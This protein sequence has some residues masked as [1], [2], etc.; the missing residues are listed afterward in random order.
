MVAPSQLV[1]DAQRYIDMNEP[2]HRHST[3][4]LRQVTD[5]LMTNPS[6]RPSQMSTE[7]QMAGAMGAYS[8]PGKMNP[9]VSPGDPGYV[10]PTASAAPVPVA[11][12]GAPGTVAP[13]P[14][15]TG[16]NPAMAGGPSV[17][18]PPSAMM[19]NRDLGGPANVGVHPETVRGSFMPTD[20]LYAPQPDGQT[21]TGGDGLPIP[22]PTY[23]NVQQSGP[24]V[25]MGTGDTN[26]TPPT[27]VPA[28][29]PPAMGDQAM[30]AGSGN[31]YTSGLADVIAAKSNGAPNGNNGGGVPPAVA[32]ESS[33]DPGPSSGGDSSSTN[34][35]KIL[36]G[37]VGG[38]GAMYG[39]ARLLR[40]TKS[41]GVAKG[42]VGKSTAVAPRGSSSTATGPALNGE[43]IPPN[44]A[45]GPKRLTAK[46]TVEQ[47]VPSTRKA[48]PSSR[49][50]ATEDAMATKMMGEPQKRL[51]APTKGKA[52]TPRQKGATGQLKRALNKAGDPR[53]KKAAAKNAAKRK[54]A[55]TKANSVGP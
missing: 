8:D 44:K 46:P 23:G 17:A 33:G 14:P 4:R 55:T 34:W 31:G 50:A 27:G 41:G 36:G 39:G 37:L 35:L 18:V 29:P 47:S 51:A 3:S 19:T 54:K 48:T 1:Q 12:P 45:G 24:K 11:R 5:M 20:P 52:K 53:G 6:M 21:Y 43:I 9:I 26:A 7:D 22:T 38:A 13:M 2:Q 40:G 25:R 42:S 30:G 16:T 15:A 49:K 10:P 28:N 32:A